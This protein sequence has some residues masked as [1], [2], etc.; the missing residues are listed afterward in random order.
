MTYGSSQTRGLIRD[1][2]I[3]IAMPDPSLCNLHRSL[4]YSHSNARSK[5]LQPTP[6]LTT[7]PNPR[8]TELAYAIAITMPDPAYAGLCYSHSNARSKPLQPTPQLTAMPNPRPTEKARDQ[9]CI[10]MDTR[11]IHFHCATTGIPSQICKTTT[12]S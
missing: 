6:Q 1:A 12:C 10:L 9:T 11:W 3:A 4:C 5:P 7:M 2:A 8:P